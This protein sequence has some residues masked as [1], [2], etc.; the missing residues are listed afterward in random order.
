MARRRQIPSVDEGPGLMME[1]LRT[2]LDAEIRKMRDQIATLSR[3]QAGMERRLG[4]L[5][6]DLEEL[7]ARL[8][9]GESSSSRRRVSPDHAQHAILGPTNLRELISIAVDHELLHLQQLRTAI[10]ALR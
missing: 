7:P 8:S 6:A 9:A 3:K 1:R 4:R 5:Q 2:E 10:E